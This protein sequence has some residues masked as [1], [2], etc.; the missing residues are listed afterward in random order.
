M[1]KAPSP[2][3]LAAR[4]KFAEAAKARAADRQNQKEELTA[5]LDTPAVATAA[6][7]QLIT[8]T[9]DQLQ[10]LFNRMAGSQS[11]DRAPAPS[12]Q[13]NGL[14]TNRSGQIVGI[15]KKYNTDANY[16]PNP[17][18]KLYDEPR[19]RRFSMRDNYYISWD[20][21]SKPYEN[22][23]GI[24]IQEPFFHATL[25]QHMFDDDGAER[26]DFMV[27][28]TLHFNED[29]QVAFD[30]AAENDIDPSE[31]NM[32]ELMDIA[33]YERCKRWIFDIF[34]PPRNF[35]MNT[36]AR[37]EAI[38]GSV[39]KVVTKSNVKG[40]GNPAPRIKDEELA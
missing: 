3:Q 37:E 18:E 25:Y 24:S 28:Q 23:Y 22:K 36:D 5:T 16:Y 9:P 4:K 1:A 12:L 21:T 30:F 10:E 40:F 7:A 11:V 39:V 32:R 29:E 38:G 19:L 6:P 2:K 17:T 14:Q 20:I 35:E 27:V 13:V 31:D 33:R 26:E 34:F 15:E 8:L